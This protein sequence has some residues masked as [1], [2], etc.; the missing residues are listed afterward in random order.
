MYRIAPW[1]VLNLVIGVLIPQI[2]NGG[3]VGGLIGGALAASVLGSRL[4]GS[5]RREALW[6]VLGA[7]VATA[8]I[9]CGVAMAFEGVQCLA[10]DDAYMACYEELLVDARVD[11]GSEPGGE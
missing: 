3:H 7:L 9:A 5:S 6:R 10:N 2:D 11:A 4:S 8:L 1:I